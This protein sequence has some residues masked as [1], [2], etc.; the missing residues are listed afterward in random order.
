MRTQSRE[1]KN[2]ERGKGV[3]IGFLDADKVNRI[4]RGKVKQFSAPGSKTSSIQLKNPERVRGGMEAE[5]A[6]GKPGA[7][8][9]DEGAEGE[10]INKMG[11]WGIRGLETRVGRECCISRPRAKMYSGGL[12]V[13]GVREE[14]HSVTAGGAA[15]RMR[16]SKSSEFGEGKL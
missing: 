8:D 12:H 4:R 14:S 1:S 15:P 9:G 11:R 6:Q 16:A 10:D 5:G 13:G 3:K 7:R 2:S